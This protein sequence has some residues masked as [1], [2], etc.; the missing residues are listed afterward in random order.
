MIIVAGMQ[1]AFNIEFFKL[2]DS[3][4][5]CL[6]QNP[7]STIVIKTK[8]VVLDSPSY[9]QRIFFIFVAFKE[10]FKSRCRKIIGLDDYFPKGLVKGGIITIMGRDAKNKMYHVAWAMVENKNFDSWMWFLNLLET[11][12]EISSSLLQT[13]IS[14]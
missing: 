10:W 9:F 1:D 11:D 8:T 3:T 4:T 13:I 6:N 12:F 2:R 14:D 7:S 5:K